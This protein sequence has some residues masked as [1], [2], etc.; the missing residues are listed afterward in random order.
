MTQ[1]DPFIHPI[2]KSLLNN[3][4]TRSFFEYLT[5]WCHDMWKRTG[6]GEDLIESGGT[7]ET[8]PWTEDT[9][10]GSRDSFYSSLTANAE[11]DQEI[12]Y[13]FPVENNFNRLTTKTI[14]NEIYTA[15]DDMFIKSKTG[16]T[17]KLPE[18]P[19][20]NCVIYAH[21]ADGTLLTINGNGRKINGHDEIVI[22]QK[23][24]GVQIYY[25]IDDND[26]VAI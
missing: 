22:R 23:G 4:D 20:D 21:N 24:N 3:P 19:S 15:V 13:N 5:R 2:P 14:N 1:V 12:S 6:G 9:T 8:Y 10:E 26:Y 25:F 16:S 11:I 7:R 18:N 17:L